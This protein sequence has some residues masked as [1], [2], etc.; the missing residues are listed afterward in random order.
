MSDDD[1]RDGEPT[2]RSSS[3]PRP[4]EE[5]LEEIVDGLGLDAEIEVEERDGVLSGA[6]DGDDVG[7]FIGR[8][9]QTIDAVQHLAQR[10]VFPDGPSSV[11]VVIDANGYRER[12]AQALR[13]EA[14]DA[15]DDAISYGQ[16]GRA[17]P[18]AAVRA[19]D[20]A[21]VP[22][23]ARRCRDAQRGRR[24][25][26]LSRRLARL[27]DWA[28][29]S[30]SR[31]NILTPGVDGARAMTELSAD[32]RRRGLAALAAAHRLDARPAGRS[33]PRLLAAARGGPTG[34]DDRCGRRSRR[35]TSISRIRSSRSSCAAPADGRDDRRLGA[36]A[37]FPGL[38]LAVALPASEV[39]LRRE[40]RAQVRVHRAGAARAAR[41]ANAAVVCARAE[42]WRQGVA[43]QR[44]SSLAR[45]LA[46]QPVVLEYAAPLLRLGGD[47]GR[48]ARRARRGRGAGGG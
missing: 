30:V 4:L 43:G 9:G 37:G 16:A 41:L 47:A 17:R 11:R 27:G 40:Q 28:A 13:A 18:A 7:L 23:R 48:L 42:E 8:H 10:I 3:R 25:G 44:S 14:D 21:R 22:A 45:A 29:R 26:A 32:V 20:R 24:A 15:A 39:A 1:G 12:R 33:S 2:A 5:L 46:P 31:E 35:W 34:A 38:A 36:G 19:A 6:L